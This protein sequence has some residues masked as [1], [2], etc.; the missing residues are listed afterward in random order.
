MQRRLAQ[1]CGELRGLSLQ[2]RALHRQEFRAWKSSKLKALLRNSGKWKEI[3]RVHATVVRQVPEQPQANEFANM[4]EQIFAGSPDELM[5]TAPVF[6]KNDWPKDEVLMAIK[7]LKANKSADETNFVAELLHFVSEYFLD[8]VL[9]FFNGL[10]HSPQVPIDWRKTIFN[11]LPKHGGV[12]V[13]AEYRPIASIRMQPTVYPTLYPWHEILHG[14][15]GRVNEFVAIHGMKLWSQRC[16]QQHYDLAHFISS[17]DDQRWVKRLMQ[18]QLH[19]RRRGG[20]QPTYGTLSSQTSAY[21]KAFNIGHWNQEIAKV[22]WQCC[23]I[24][25][26]DEIGGNL[27]WTTSFF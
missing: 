8:R 15:N 10:M 12:K 16:V 11:M 20:D 9:K 7:R 25:L 26:I 21:G 27:V 17:L 1:D 24:S 13:P 18:W 19:G 5:A 3:S 14:W 6:S 22:G 2:I 4:L 23:L